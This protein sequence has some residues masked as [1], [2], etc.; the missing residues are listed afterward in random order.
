MDFKYIV[1]TALY[2]LGLVFTGIVYNSIV[3]IIV[4]VLLLLLTSITVKLFS[5]NSKIFYSTFQVYCILTF[6]HG[7]SSLY[8]LDMHGP[9]ALYFYEMGISGLSIDEMLKI[10][11]GAAIS[12]FGLTYSIFSYIGIQPAYYIG[13]ML[14]V[15]LMTI[16]FVTG[17]R[18][19]SILTSVTRR[20]FFWYRVLYI[21]SG[22]FMLFAT[23]HLRAAI[24]LLSF[25]LLVLFWT[26]V[27]EKISI[28]KLIIISLLTILTIPYFKLLRTE[29]YLVP[30][31]V[32]LT[33]YFSIFF[34]SVSKNIKI[35]LTIIL[36]LSIVFAILIAYKG[37]ASFFEI[38][39][40]VFEYGV[41]SYK[42]GA[43]LEGKGNSLGS[44]L[45]VQQP[46]SLRV[47]IGTIYLFLSPFPFYNGIFSSNAYHFFKSLHAIQMIFVF[48]YFL[49]TLIN[50]LKNNILKDTSALF[51]AILFIGFSVSVAITSLDTRHHGIFLLLMYVLIVAYGPNWRKYKD[52]LSMYVIAII[53]LIGMHT[54]LKL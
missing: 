37:A 4:S 50:I 34:G 5:K 51:I 38:F 27:L 19:L 1:T 31:I 46:T 35:T 28:K 2:L 29:F 49:L 17:Y 42:E 6:W 48:P 20:K 16:S 45:I 30:I 43:I 11:N 9:D 13:S 22:M 12:I 14:N 41:S 23:I 53:I 39:N 7:I 10:E 15:M 54:V 24:I 33:A 40:S 32:M 25:S 18:I 47:F 36:F 52:F 44:A 21:T 26:S 8:G 3:P